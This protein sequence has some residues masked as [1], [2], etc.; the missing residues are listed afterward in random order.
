MFCS[1]EVFTNCN[2]RRSFHGAH[3]ICRLSYYAV[4]AYQQAH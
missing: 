4:I 1:D 3:A 2:R